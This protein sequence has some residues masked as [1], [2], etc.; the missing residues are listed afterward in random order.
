M[1]EDDSA[2][3]PATDLRAK[4]DD[5][6]FIARL[7]S[8]DEDALDELTAWLYLKLPGFITSGFW[9]TPKN[10]NV[11]TEHVHTLVTDLLFQIRTRLHR[12]EYRGPRSFLNWMRAVIRNKVIDELRKRGFPPKTVEFSEE[13]HSLTSLFEYTTDVLPDYEVNSP[14]GTVSNEQGA[15]DLDS[16]GPRS[17]EVKLALLAL[18]YLDDR[19]RDI[20][21]SLLKEH[22]DYETIAREEL[23]RE[24]RG[25]P[26]TE[27]ALKRRIV[28][29]RQ[30]RS[31]AMKRFSQIMAD[32]RAGKRVRKKRTRSS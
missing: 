28:A 19:Y 8:G 14:V 31:R 4:L 10:T 22:K 15:G 27:A 24:Y 16:A 30:L 7:Q 18:I 17:D 29:L 13:E 5:A 1:N 2:K 6:E 20:L 32:L 11:P 12:F 26:M 3:H 9:Q 25:A 21:V 23:A